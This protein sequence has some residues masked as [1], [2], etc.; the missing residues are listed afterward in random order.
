MVS[1]MR[2]IATMRH[3]YLDRLLSRQH[4]DEIRSGITDRAT[5]SV[6]IAAGTAPHER[7]QTT[8]YSVM[9]NNGNAAAVTY[10]LNGAFGAGV[11]AEDTGFL[12]NNEMD[13]FT[14]KPG[15]PNMFGLVQGEANLIAPGKRPLSSM[16]PTIVLKD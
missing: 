4:I 8:S 12:M 16:A 13:D 7:P 10:T 2:W 1:I 6:Q 3:A 14:I 9:D 11:M 5:P 15:T